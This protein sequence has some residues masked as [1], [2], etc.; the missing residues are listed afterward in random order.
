[1]HRLPRPRACDPTSESLEPIQSARAEDD[2][3]AALSEHDRSRLAYSTARP[4]YDDDLVFDSV[5][6][7]LHF[8]YLICLDLLGSEP[9]NSSSSNPISQAAGENRPDGFEPEI[10]VRKAERDGA[11]LVETPQ[12]LGRKLHLEAPEVILELG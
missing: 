12:V 8:Q 2:L 1:V 7:V 5:H 10:V 9:M 3:R 4:G 6:E 11:D